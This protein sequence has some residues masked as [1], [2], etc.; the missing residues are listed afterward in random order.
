M[1]RRKTR[2]TQYLLDHTRKPF[3]L[4]IDHAAVTA[5]LR[6]T[7]CDPVREILTRGQDDCQGRSQL[8]GDTC[9]E[10]HLLLRQSVRPASGSHQRRDAHSHQQ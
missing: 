9:D 3:G 5:H 7:V 10:L 4:T 6:F 1:L 8:M 2:E